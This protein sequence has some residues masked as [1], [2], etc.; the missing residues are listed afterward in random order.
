SAQSST[1]GPGSSQ[2]DTVAFSPSCSAT[3]AASP[4]ATSPTSESRFTRRL[5]YENGYQNGNVT[6]RTKPQGSAQSGDPGTR[7]TSPA[8]IGTSD[9][10][11][12]PSLATLTI[13]CLASVPPFGC[14]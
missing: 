6:I 7:T 1:N 11:V 2:N 4:P 13:S 5:S 8:R 14:S 3:S 12:L 10:P 9:P